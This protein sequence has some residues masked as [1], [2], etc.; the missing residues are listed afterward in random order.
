MAKEI[1]LSNEERKVLKQHL[2]KWLSKFDSDEVLREILLK[3]TYD[4]YF[5]KE[6]IERY[7]GVPLADKWNFIHDECEWDDMEEFHNLLW[8][9]LLQV[10]DKELCKYLK[11]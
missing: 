4:F 11:D 1:L 9:F 2:L 5:D 7:V 6:T 10:E 3:I 8:D